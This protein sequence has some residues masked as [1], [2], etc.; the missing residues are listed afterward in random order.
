MASHVP[1]MFQNQIPLVV[2]SDQHN[3][4]LNLSDSRIVFIK[5]CR[6]RSW[7]QAPPNQ[8]PAVLVTYTF[9]RLATQNGTARPLRKKAALCRQVRLS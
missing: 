2:F 4:F 1:V 9:A 7:S 3:F 6:H 5:H 8:G